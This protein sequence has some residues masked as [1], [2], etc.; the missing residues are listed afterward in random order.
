MRSDI[1]KGG[2]TPIKRADFVDGKKIRDD[3][4]VL[5]EIRLHEGEYLYIIDIRSQEKNNLCLLYPILQ[6]SDLF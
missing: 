5:A 3:V 6:K 4:P 1:D 2:R